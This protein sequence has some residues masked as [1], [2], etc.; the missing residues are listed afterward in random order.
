MAPVLKAELEKV[1]FNLAMQ[2]SEGI[3]E[4][5]DNEHGF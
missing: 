4:C 2:R 5:C 1:G 3:I